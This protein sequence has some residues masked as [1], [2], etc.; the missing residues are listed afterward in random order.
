MTW[1]EAKEA[2][3]VYCTEIATPRNIYEVNKITMGFKHLMDPEKYIPDDYL[4]AE[5]KYEFGPDRSENP[6]DNSKEHFIFHFNM[7]LWEYRK[8]WI[9]LNDL[10]ETGRWKYIFS[11]VPGYLTY[12]FWY[13]CDAESSCYL[14]LHTFHAVDVKKN[15]IL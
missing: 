12:D 13:P 14:Q 9:G 3:E 6:R 4:T 7:V 8:Y 15:Y 10:E 2:C 11:I 1:S 5:N